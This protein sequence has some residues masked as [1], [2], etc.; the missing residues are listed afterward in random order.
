[1]YHCVVTSGLEIWMSGTELLFWYAAATIDWLWAK[2]PWVAGEK[3][4]VV[5]LADMIFQT[6]SSPVGGRRASVM[7]VQA[8]VA[9]GR[10]YWK[11]CSS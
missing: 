5:L 1:M 2:C 9:E 11:E 10:P 6:R 3:G 7:R 8:L 4:C